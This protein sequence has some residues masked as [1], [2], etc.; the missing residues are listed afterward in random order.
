[1]EVRYTLRVFITAIAALLFFIDHNN[2]HSAQRLLG[3]P[4]HTGGSYF[5]TQLRVIVTYIRLLFLPLNQNL[6][7]DFP[8]IK[9]LFS[10]PALGSLLLL[11]SIITGAIRASSKYKLISFGILWFFIT[12]LLESSVIPCYD[13]ISE[14]RLYLSVVGYSLF[15]V[16]GIYY[17]FGDKTVTAVA[18][19][20]IVIAGYSILTY[21]RNFIWKDELTLWND[22]VRKSPHK[23]RPYNSRGL[24]YQNQGDFSQAISDY[25]QAL[26]INPNYAKAYNNRGNIYYNQGNL[27]Q[28]LSDCDQAIKINPN[29]AKAYSNRGDIYYDQG[30]L[31]QAISD[32]DQ[33]LQINPNYAAAYNNLGN[34]YYDKGNLG[35]A[36]SDYDQAIKNNSKLA[37]AYY[38]RALVY[39]RKQDY[40]KSW[41]DIYKAEALGYK[42]K[43]EFIAELKKVSGRQK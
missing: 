24:A 31:G 11:T 38:N 42:V 8:M 41:E 28:A 19:L 20:L 25:N 15:L 39:F 30:N 2:Y 6:D 9:S 13:V 18:I 43:P 40:N 21:R 29:Y 1:L 32:Y 27:S 17:F 36:L 5:L 35:E 16:S 7:Y 33:A 22:V 12:L 23:A 4:L 14:H 37:E 26:Q 34:V 10:L 3:S